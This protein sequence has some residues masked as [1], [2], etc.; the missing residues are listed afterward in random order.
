M[1]Q[2][3]QVHQPVVRYSRTDYTALRAWVQR[4]PVGKVRE[5]YYADDA[6]QVRNGLEP[7]LTGMR[8]ALIERAI[9]ANPQLATMLAKARQ[10]GPIS[11]GV[12]DVLVKAADAK[13][14]VPAPD[15]HI[16]QWLRVKV[17][18]QLLGAGID[19]L[20]ALK[21]FIED[22]GS[23]W[24]RPIPRI[25]ALRA[26][27]LL[28]WL[29]HY[30]QLAVDPRTQVAKTSGDLAQIFS[31][32]ADKPLPLER[33][34]SLP[35][36]LDGC[37]GNNR[38]P[39]FCYLAACNDLEALQAYVLKFRRQPH[40]AR[41]YQRELERFLLWCVLVRKKPLSSVLV[42]DCEAYKDFLQAPS[43]AFAGPRR[44]RFAPQWKPFAGPLSTESQKQAVQILR[45]AFGWLHAVRYLG[46]NP[47]VAVADPKPD[48]QIHAMQIERALSESL[49][50]RVIATVTAL[51]E[52]P[53]ASQARI[54][55]SALLLMGDCGLR[56]SEVSE[57]R[58]DRLEPSPF[59][60]GRYRL[61]VLGKGK[62][63]RAVPL[64]Q[65]AHAALL[66]HN[67]DLVERYGQRPRPDTALIRPLALPPT[68]ATAERHAKAWLGYAPNALGRVIKRVLERVASQA[69]SD[70]TERQTNPS[71]SD[72][73][74]ADATKLRN[75]SSH[76]LR[77]TFATLASA[78]EMPL[79]V[80]Q[81]ILGHA[82]LE[83]TS[84]YVQAQERRVAAEAE[85]FH[86]QNDDK[87]RV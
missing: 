38:S 8:H 34:G 58:A 81:K 45:K 11:T 24:W 35:T 80:V 26:R 63:L 21:R 68:G 72:S 61:T 66:S 33:I 7:F 62:K 71:L 51:A 44:A 30:P 77:H 43:P 17:A 42:D 37:K 85:R 36:G 70:A 6:P 65:R 64:S 82:S 27:A 12:L 79:D 49:Y 56:I 28:R 67:A 86:A 48:E 31:P 50:E 18:T 39:L 75:T 84:I 5:L 13:P 87:S 22:A 23:G 74:Q 10:G 73:A 32:L 9:L 69:D 25:G 14:S 52:E 55:L 83:T 76:G 1:S 60:P 40:T 20:G 15:D 29:G 41:A 78:R 59:V 53:D 16:G 57:A 46:G 54:A 2:H 3:A 19:T 47:W 4:V